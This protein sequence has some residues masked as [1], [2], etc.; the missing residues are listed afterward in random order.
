M[1]ILIFAYKKKALSKMKMNYIHLLLFV[2]YGQPKNNIIVNERNAYKYEYV[3]KWKDL[4][5]S[6]FGLIHFVSVLETII[7]FCTQIQ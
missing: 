3:L 4:L 5:P 1:L 6:C 2:L 7:C